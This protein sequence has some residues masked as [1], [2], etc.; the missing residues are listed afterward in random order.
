MTYNKQSLRY[1]PYIKNKHESIFKRVIKEVKKKSSTKLLNEITKD[2]LDIIRF[3]AS[4]IAFNKTRNEVNAFIRTGL[5]MGLM[6]GLTTDYI[7]YNMRLQN[8]KKVYFDHYYKC[9]IEYYINKTFNPTNLEVNHRCIANEQYNFDNITNITNNIQLF[10]DEYEVSKIYHE[11]IDVS[12]THYLNLITKSRY[13]I[14]DDIKFM[15]DN[16]LLSSNEANLLICQN[17]DNKSLD[18]LED[19]LQEEKIK[20]SFIP[21]LE[22]NINTNTN[23]MIID[24]DNIDVDK[25]VFDKDDFNPLSFI[26]DSSELSMYIH[27]SEII[28]YVKIDDFLP[29][30]NENKCCVFCCRKTKV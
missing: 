6:M 13:D 11:L 21:Y 23:E 12:I 16:N 2:E 15:L 7:D 9:Y 5:M 14:E 29:L 8:L 27:P 4:C 20:I 30:C 24:F 22:L 28:K 18:E 1:Q 26:I 10:I 17:S 3:R 25:I 19:I